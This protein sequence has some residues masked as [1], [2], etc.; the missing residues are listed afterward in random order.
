MTSSFYLQLILW[1]VN[2][3]HSFVN[4]CV[5][6]SRSFK[7]VLEA[8]LSSLWLLW[9]S[10]ESWQ[11]VQDPSRQSF[12]RSPQL[13]PT[14]LSVFGCSTLSPAYNLWELNTK[15]WRM[16]VKILTRMQH[17]YYFLFTFLWCG[18]SLKD[19]WNNT[20]IFESNNNIQNYSYKILC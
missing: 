8:E 1:M 3:I 7:I 16:M 6:F 17:N 2:N 19:F 4:C 10:V 18:I 20:N 14:F 12:R 13:V 11:F 15:C 5:K 9:S